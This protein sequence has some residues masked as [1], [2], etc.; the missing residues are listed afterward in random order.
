MPF[1]KTKPKRFEA[2]Q[3]TGPG[4]VLDGVQREWTEAGGYTY[5][6]VTAHGQRVYLEPGD[7]IRAEPD[8]RGHYP[9]K[10]DIFPTLCDPDESPP[11]A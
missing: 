9:I 3:W 8:G 6:V 1:F 7:W 5:H 2:H 11:D 4:C 10:A